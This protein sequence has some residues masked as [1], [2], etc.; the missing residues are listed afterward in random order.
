MLKR[1]YIA[2]F[3][4][5]S[6]FAAWL[7]ALQR[8]EN[9]QAAIPIENRTVMLEVPSGKMKCLPKIPFSSGLK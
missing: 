2:A 7:V 9:L 1:T 5:A 3:L 6:A 4:V 8:Q